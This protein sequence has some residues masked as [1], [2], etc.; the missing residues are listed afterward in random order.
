MP[1][2]EEGLEWYEIPNFPDYWLTKCGKVGSTKQ[3]KYIKQLG[4]REHNQKKDRYIVG[5]LNAEG[6]RVNIFIHTLVL[7]VFRGP[8]PSGMQ[9][10]HLNGMSS[11]NRLENLV[12]GTPQ[13][14]SDDRKRHGTSNEGSRNP[15][16]KL[17]IEKAR[18]IRRIHASEGI[19]KAELARRY[20]VSDVCI[21][22]IIT[23]Q[24][25]KEKD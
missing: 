9:C 22:K 15:A 5:L 8:R 20:N 4:R 25:W 7:T 24:T 1:R 2:T 23:E 11:D 16:S 3:S 13:E 10:R 19:S 21:H 17:T 18:E 6:K 14:N 12:W